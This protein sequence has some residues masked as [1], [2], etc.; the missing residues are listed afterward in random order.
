MKTIKYIRK[1][2]YKGSDQ[3]IFEVTGGEAEGDEAKQYQIGRYISS[4]E[5]IW[6]ILGFSIIDR[7]PVVTHLEVHLGHGEWIYFTEA[8]VCRALEP[9]EQSRVEQLI[10]L[11]IKM[12][13]NS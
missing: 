13:G 7:D 2:V 9:P 6:R 4:N 11:Y 10:F 12:M 1:Y 3:A 5:A 8:S